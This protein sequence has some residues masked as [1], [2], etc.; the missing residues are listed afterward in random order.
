MTRLRIPDSVKECDKLVSDELILATARKHKA[1]D[2]RERKMT[3]TLFFWSLVLSVEDK[4]FHGF[5]PAMAAGFERLSGKAL[6]KS[7]V[8]DQMKRRDWRWFKELYGQLLQEQLPKLGDTDLEFLKE[9]A[10]FR[11]AD[12]TV[13]GLVKALRGKFRATTGGAALKMHT[14][15]SVNSFVALK[16]EVTEQCSADVKFKFLSNA[17]NV[18]YA[19]DLGYWD[20]DLLKGIMKRKSFFVSRLKAGADVTILDFLCRGYSA[21]AGHRMELKELLESGLG[22]DVFDA[23]VQLGSIWKIRLVGLKHGDEWY[24]YVT[25]LT[26]PKF[27]PQSIYEM[28]RMR[29]QI[30]IFFKELKSL[31]SLRHI[32]TRNENAVMLEIYAALIFYLLTRS[33]MA[34]AEPRRRLSVRKALAV[35]KRRLMDV[36]RPMLIG[37]PRLFMAELRSL[38]GSLALCKPG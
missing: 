14:L 2:T 21:S 4:A 31:V 26:D 30:E 25:N 38:L 17:K 11:I 29:W 13:I 20:Y 22:G 5:Y 24:F 3:T 23:L 28:Y 32:T 7:A 12:S 1:G 15:F 27:T 34:R 37:K 10:D 35:V 9:F 19:F 16:V 6:S 8:K 36:V 18:L 33:L